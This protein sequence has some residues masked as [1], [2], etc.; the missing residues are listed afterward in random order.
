[1]KNL[2]FAGVKIS[3]VDLLNQWHDLLQYSKEFLS[4]GLTNY[5]KTWQKINSSPQFCGW[6]D[7]LTLIELLFTI[8][9]SNTKLQC[10]L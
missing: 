3:S 7:I 6:K 10:V 8:P 2:T 1:M 5:I 9:V 4:T